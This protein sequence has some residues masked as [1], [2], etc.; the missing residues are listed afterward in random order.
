MRKQPGYY[1][2]AQVSFGFGDMGLGGSQ[3]ATFMIG[4]FLEGKYDTE[5][6]PMIVALCKAISE[7]VES[8]MKEKRN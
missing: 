7:A 3:S 4:E 8:D 5:D 1:D 2:I 6:G